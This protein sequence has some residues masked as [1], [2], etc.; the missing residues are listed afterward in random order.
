MN[1][2]ILLDKDCAPT[3]PDIL[4]SIGV[5]V[6]RNHSLQQQKNHVHVRDWDG[7]GFGQPPVLRIVLG[8]P[9]EPK[10]CNLRVGM[11]Q[12]VCGEMSKCLV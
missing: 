9:Q 11:Q 4:S 12:K 1:L 3:S 2:S 10:F 6:W 8:A 7:R 5:W